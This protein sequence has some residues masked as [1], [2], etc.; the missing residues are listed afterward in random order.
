VSVRQRV[1][2]IEQKNVFK[3]WASVTTT[4]LEYRRSSGEWQE[5]IREVYDH[6]DGAAILLYNP[7]RRSIVLIRQFRYACLFTGHDDLMIEVPAGLVD[8]MAPDERIRLEA[9]E[10]TGF[11]V[12]H[13]HKIME[14]FASPGSM[15]ERIHLYVAEYSQHDRVSKGGGHHHEGEDIEVLE[16]PF[17]DALTMIA[18][19]RI[20][21]L[22]TVVLVQYAALHIFNQI[23]AKLT[24]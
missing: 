13:I 18:D 12:E 17:D 20:V 1:R 16:L 5:Q 21:D 15:T 10:E 8:D 19:G 4:K 24:L 22:K 2:I 14:A 3:G 9:E 23:P 6:G 7:A 11:R